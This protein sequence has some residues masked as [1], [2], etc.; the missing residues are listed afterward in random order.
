MTQQELEEAAAE[1]ATVMYRLDRIFHVSHNVTVEPAMWVISMRRQQQMYLDPRM[2]P[3][4]DTAGLLPLARLNQQWFKLDEP[5]DVAYQLGLPVDGETISGC[6]SEFPRFMPGVGKP[7][8]E[9]F[10]DLFGQRL[11]VAV[12]EKLTVTFGWFTETFAELP[13]DASEEMVIKHARAY[14]VML[15]T[16]FWR[17]DSRTGPP[18]MALFPR[19]AGGHGQI[20]L[21]F[22]SVGLGIPKPFFG[23]P[24]TTW[25]RWLR[26]LPTSDEKDLRLAQF[27]VQLDR[28]QPSK[29]HVQLCTACVPLIYF[30]A[31]EWHPDD[32]VVPQF[33]GFKD[34]PGHP[35]NIDF[36]HSKDGR[37]G[38]RWFPHMYQIWHG[39]WDAREEHVMVIPRVDDRGIRA[40]P[41]LVVSG[42]EEIPVC[43]CGIC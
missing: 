34:I 11:A 39:M 12:I 17:Q 7:A 31:I 28:L 1:A 36:L 18:S 32:R 19:S 20:Q 6:L 35:I 25:C 9:W 14:I 16:T 15:Y 38:D 27:R 3:Y 13:L 29:R 22:C 5:L 40:I 4:L 26:Y 2:E 30:G 43:G 23:A 24:T 37:R 42:R 8:W 41:S 10:E 33:G 21:G